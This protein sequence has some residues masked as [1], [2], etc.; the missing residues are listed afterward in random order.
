M[1]INHLAWDQAM[2]GDQ[3]GEGV[4]LQAGVFFELVAVLA[5]IHIICFQIAFC[6][7]SS[8]HLHCVQQSNYPSFNAVL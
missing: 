6:F 1:W 5:T 3:D 7:I 4:R 2:W 8:I